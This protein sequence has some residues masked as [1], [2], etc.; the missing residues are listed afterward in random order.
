MIVNIIIDEKPLAVESGCTILETARANHIS[1]PTLC[2]FDGLKNK[3]SCR[4]CVVEVEGKKNLQ[5]ACVTKVKEGMVIHTNN[6][7]VRKERKYILVQI[8]A[9]HTVD[10]HHCLRIGL[11]DA[12]SLD[13]ELCEMCFWCDC[14]RDGFCEL[15]TLAREYRVGVI[16]DY[17]SAQENNYI[18]EEASLGS[19]M[20]NPDK[21]IHCRRCE[22]VCNRVQTVQNVGSDANIGSLFEGNCVQC[23]HC[24]DVCPV[25]AFYMQE[26]K[27]EILY[28]THSYDTDTIAQVSEDIIPE[29]TALYKLKPGDISMEQI[30]AALRKIGVN[31]VISDE[32][33]VLTAAVQAAKIIEDNIEN[34]T[35]FITNSNAVLNF[36]DRFFPNLKEMIHVYESIQSIFGR[37]AEGMMDDNRQIET[38]YQDDYMDEAKNKIHTRPYKKVQITSEKEAGA[39]AAASGNADYVVNA[40]ELYRIFIRTGGAPARKIPVVFDAVPEQLE[41]NSGKVEEISYPEILGRKQWNLDSEPESVSVIINGKS[42]NCAIAH[43]LGQ[44]RKLLEGD[45]KSYD[46]V[47][48]M[49]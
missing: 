47:R 38:G 31:K 14:V 10:C 49:A 23:G 1:I 40:R 28:W 37:I 33:A 11:C 25:G 18:E 16:P 35:V 29:L 19:I 48:L 26:H 5:P 2:H 24:V 20:Y 32:H 42:R 6:E 44:T 13:P 30:C 43:N 39:E 4:I 15:Q 12:N 7:R 46:V 21:C 22:D 8:L 3:A 41:M 27:D 34:G 17:M 9:N 36:V 45:W